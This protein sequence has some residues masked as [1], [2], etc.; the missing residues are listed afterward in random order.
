MLD[1]VRVATLV[2]DE[3]RLDVLVPRHRTEAKGC[4]TRQQTL[5]FILS[6]HLCHR[7]TRYRTG[8][9]VATIIVTGLYAAAS[10]LLQKKKILYKNILLESDSRPLK[11]YY[12]L[13][14]ASS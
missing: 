10:P 2:P 13:K 4:T 3:S 11:K 14:Q 1:I 8:K 5:V 12:S 9:R 7:H 6:H